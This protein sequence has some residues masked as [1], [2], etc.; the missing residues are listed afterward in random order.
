MHTVYIKSSEFDMLIDVD[1]LERI[2]FSE[3]KIFA[4]NLY[5]EKYPIYEGKAVNGNKAL[6]TIAGVVHSAKR[7][8]ETDNQA[9]ILDF[10][11][12]LDYP[13][14][15]LPLTTDITHFKRLEL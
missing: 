15:A 3:N 14:I 1:N 4:H 5:E 2:S 10:T 6:V 8:S 9:V 12:D 13:Q 11:K 7:H